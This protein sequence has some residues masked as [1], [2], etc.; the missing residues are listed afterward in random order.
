MD[1]K[2]SIG[3]PHTLWRSRSQHSRKVFTLQTIP[4]WED[5][6][7]GTSQ[8][9]KIVVSLYLLVLQQKRVNARSWNACV[10]LFQ[11]LTYQKSVVVDL[12]RQG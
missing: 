5:D 6:D 2:A 7:Y 10:N 9:G 1:V 12:A 8:V 11:T 4:S 3:L